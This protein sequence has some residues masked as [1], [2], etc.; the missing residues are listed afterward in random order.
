MMCRHLSAAIL[1]AALV[2]AVSG[3]STAQDMVRGKAKVESGDSL[4][5]GDHRIR[6]AGIAAPAPRD[7]CRLYDIGWPCGRNSKVALLQ[8]IAGRE[9]ACTPEETEAADSIVATCSVGDRDIGEAMVRS[10]HARARGRYGDAQVEA[11]RNSR[12]V[13]GGLAP[14]N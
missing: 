12:G 4:R 8:I 10:G 5:I 14:Q 2:T 1:L 11:Q 6:L 3:P 7:I 13:W 9:I